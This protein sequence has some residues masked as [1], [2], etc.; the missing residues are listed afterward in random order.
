MLPYIALQLQSVTL[1]FGVFAIEDPQGWNPAN[2]ASTGL[3]V[4]G[5]LALF[6]ILFGK[7]LL[8]E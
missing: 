3:W 6:T 2:P 8:A 1:S 5:G 7:R 4:A